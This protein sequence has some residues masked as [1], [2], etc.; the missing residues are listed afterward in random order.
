MRQPLESDNR[1]SKNR[2]KSCRIAA[3]ELELAELKKAA[4]KA[5]HV[6]P[7]QPAKDEG[8]RIVL[9]EERTSF[10][11]PTQK[12]LHALHDYHSRQVSAVLMP[13][14]SCGRSPRTS[15]TYFPDWAATSI[16]FATAL[17]VSSIA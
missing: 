16:A 17:A 13:T 5:P 3:L 7:P 11:R 9:L 2:R 10:V 8:V 6:P 15:P 14:K 1:H 12:E 4:G